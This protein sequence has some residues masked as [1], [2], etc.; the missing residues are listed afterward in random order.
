MALKAMAHPQPQQTVEYRITPD[1]AAHLYRVRMR[2]HG[3]SAGR[4]EISMAAWIPGS[5]M[6]RDFARHLIS[7]EARQDERPLALLKQD[8]QTWVF[9]VKEGD[10]DID[11]EVYA[12]D[13]SVRSAHLDTTHA[14]FN[15]TAIFLAVRGC[16]HAPHTV[17]LLPPSG[18]DFRRWR[19]ATSLSAMDTL[20]SGFG[21]YQ[22]PS[23]EDLIDHPVEM[24]A[25]ER[26]SF[27]VAGVPHDLVVSGRH[28][29]D[30]DRFCRDLERICETHRALFGDLPLERY[31]FLL[32]LV[33]DGYGGL[34]HKS[35]TSLIC[36]RSDLPRP[37]Q[38]GVTEG[39]C[40]LLG[41]CSHEYF[42]LWNVKRIRPQAFMEASLDREVHTG[43]LWAFEGIT[44]YY[45]DLALVRSGV[46]GELDYLTLLAHTITR[47]LR[48]T[49]RLKQT[50]LESSFDAWTKFYKQ[51]ENAPNAIVSYYA[52]GA[53]VALA[54][55]LHIRLESGG[56]KSLEDVMR[57]LW[58]HYG[59]PGLGVPE[60]G[61]ERA[62][63]EATGLDLSDFFDRALRST[64]D[65]PLARLLDRFGIEMQLR[66][67][68]DLKDL[69]GASDRPADEA[70]AVKK[71][72]GV[73]FAAD[74][75]EVRIAQVFDGSAARAAGLAVGD[76]LLAVD[77]IRATPGNIRDLIA[78][79]Q[80]SCQ[81]HLFRRD[82]LLS[83]RVTPQPPPADTCQLRLLHGSED[84]AVLRRRAWLQPAEG[85]D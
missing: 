38:G 15:G 59:R 16:E 6:I 60:D 77:G 13:L 73:R 72:L 2:I 35:S 14:Y 82:E 17:A 48:G 36:S 62:A 3:L 1:P 29:G 80:T 61:V 12:F 71:G 10:V 47:V 57:F 51:D 69:G 70:P 58:C 46:I 44:S 50:L 9:E 37:A 33:S 41:L 4:M 78:D 83:L 8:K 20:P 65:L 84:A 22:A 81:I 63:M 7:I 49:G 32:T 43:L 26:R 31:L 85:V 76:V 39:Y 67:A 23:Y 75:G 52:K 56:E 55:D 27:E 53:L 28:R 34:E 45:D 74:T 21:R 18:D 11:Y 79:T 64:E 54:L 42:H 24:G 68:A 30:V 25:F 66:P 40:R 19:V 5:Y